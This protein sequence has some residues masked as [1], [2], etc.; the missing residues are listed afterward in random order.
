M[1][2]ECW[3]MRRRSSRWR[4]GQ[5]GTPYSPFLAQH[6]YCPLST[7][8]FEHSVR[9]STDCLNKFVGTQLMRTLIV[10]PPFGNAK[11]VWPPTLIVW[12][13][14]GNAQFVC[15]QLPLGLWSSH[16]SRVLHFDLSNADVG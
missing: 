1:A 6:P 10:W 14:F 5:K 16:F 4:R 2:G 11:F 9:L 8:V 12:P 7:I 3:G 15:H 13:P